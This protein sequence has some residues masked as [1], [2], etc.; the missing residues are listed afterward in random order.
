[1]TKRIVAI[2]VFG[3]SIKILNQVKCEL[4]SIWVNHVEEPYNDDL[5]GI[6]QGLQDIEISINALANRTRRNMEAK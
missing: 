6:V 2:R 4:E 5:H 3:F 1:M